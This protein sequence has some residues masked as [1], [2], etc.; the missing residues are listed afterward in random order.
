[1]RAWTNDEST[2]L[3]QEIVVIG[4]HPQ[5]VRGFTHHGRHSEYEFEL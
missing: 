2:V 4:L 5:E 3:L 1:M